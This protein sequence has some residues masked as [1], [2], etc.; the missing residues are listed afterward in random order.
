MYLK[1]KGRLAR[2][3]IFVN[4]NNID[5]VAPLLQHRFNH[6]TFTMVCLTNETIDDRIKSKYPKVVFQT[7]F[8]FNSYGSVISLANN[9]EKS[10]IDNFDKLM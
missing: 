3:L 9:G 8:D 7:G 4:A 2:S 10:Y 1:N 5:Q 6:K